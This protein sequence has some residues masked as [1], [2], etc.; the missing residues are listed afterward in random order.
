M[1]A[2]GWCWGLL[3]DLW[4]RNHPALPYLQPCILCLGTSRCG[5]PWDA[6]EAPQPHPT[7]V[8]WLTVAVWEEGQLLHSPSMV[9]MPLVPV[10]K[11]E[12]DNPFKF[13]LPQFFRLRCGHGAAATSATHQ[14]PR[15][16]PVTQG[17]RQV[18]EG[19]R[20]KSHFPAKKKEA[21]AALVLCQA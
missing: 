20:G 5:E 9:T 3:Q 18:W 7:F 21:D 17:F 10:W 1:A 6:Q 15:F 4:N 2:W 16:C 19:R 13:C 14:Q 8:P 12:R 11:W